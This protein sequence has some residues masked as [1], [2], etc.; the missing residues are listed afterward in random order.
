MNQPEPE[1]RITPPPHVLL[2][3]GAVGL[4]APLRRPQSQSPAGGGEEFGQIA[5]R[6][7]APGPERQ[8]GPAL[9]RTG[10]P[11]NSASK[12][13]RDEKGAPGG[14]PLL[15]PGKPLALITFLALSPGR[16]ASR[17]FLLDLLWADMDTD[18]G[19][20][21][22]RQTLWQIRQLLGEHAFEGREEIRLG[23]PVESDRD[24]FLAAIDSGDLALAVER[25]TGHFLP[26]FAAPGGAEFE[27]WA[28]RERDRLR[29]LFIRA[30]DTLARRHLAGGRPRD[31]VHLA[32][33]IREA[34]PMH[35]GGWRLLLEAVLATNDRVH[36]LVEADALE[37]LLRTEGRESEPATRAILRSVRQSPDT[38]EP[39]ATTTLMAELVGREREFR[40]LTQAWDQ[41][42]HG[43]SA[44]ILLSA[45]AG[46][47]KSRLL[48]DFHARLKTLGARTVLV[49]A[50]PGERDLAGA[51]AADLAAA[52][53][54]LPGSGA[55]SPAA[56][57]T[58]VSLNP[59]LSARFSG[60]THQPESTDQI[61]QR[62]IALA[63]LVQAVAWEAPVAILVDD[64]HWADP[65]STRILL[66]VQPRIATARV[67]LLG[68]T[69]HDRTRAT[70]P[71]ETTI[72]PLEPLSPSD[73][74]N[75]LT[76]LGRLSPG[77]EC[78]TL[79]VTL[80][81]ASG[82]SPLHV[83]DALTLALEKEHLALTGSAWEVK[84][85][86]GLVLEV[87]RGGSIAG[88]VGDLDRAAAWVLT[89]LAT[90]GAPCPTDLVVRASGREGEE[91]RTALRLLEQRGF[92]S[93]VGREWEVAHDEIAETA[94][95]IADPATRRAA[96]RA[97][98]LALA[99]DAGSDE[100]T[101]RR[102]LQL[103]LAGG[104]VHEVGSLILKIRPTIAQL[105]SAEAQAARLAELL[106]RDAE[107]ADLQ[108]VVAGM[109]R[110]RRW[111]WL[112]T[113][114][115]VLVVVTGTAVAV[116]R[117][118]GDA[119]FP[120]LYV[121]L[122]EDSKPSEVRRVV[123]RPEEW[124]TRS[125]FRSA[126]TRIQTPDGPHA[127]ADAA[128]AVRGREW[129]LY[130][131][132]SVDN[133]RTHEVARTSQDGTAYLTDIP[134]DDLFGSLSPDRR[135]IVFA[136]ARWSPPGGDHLDLAIMDSLGGSVHQLTSSPAVEGSPRWDHSGTRIAFV[137]RFREIQPSEV[138]VITT[139]GVPLGCHPLP[140]ADIDDLVGWV[141]PATL[142]VTSSGP[143]GTSILR[144]NLG[145]G[146][147]TEFHPRA[148]AGYLS[149]SPD[150]R[151]VACHCPGFNGEPVGLRIVP[152]RDPADSRLVDLPPPGRI[153]GLAWDS[154]TVNDAALQRIDVTGLGE[155]LARDV[156]HAP[157]V[158]G[159]SG[160]GE[161]MPIPPGVL[162]WW[163]ADTAVIHVD[164]ASG[165]MTPR[166]EGAATIRLTAGG[167]R[168]ATVRVEV[169]G[170]SFQ[171]VLEEQWSALDTT[172]WRSYGEPTPRLGRGPEGTAGLIPNGDGSYP[173]GAYS[174]SA[175]PVAEG[176]G[177][178]AM[179]SAPV[180]RTFWQNIGLNLNRIDAFTGLDQ[181]DHVAGAPPSLQDLEAVHCGFILPAGE[182]AAWL[183][184]AIV[185]T[186]REHQ[187]IPAPPD[188][189]DGRWWTLRVQLFPDGSC[190]YAFNGVPVA[191]SGPGSGLER[192]YRLWL[193][194]H[195]MGTTPMFGPL[196][197]WTGV[198]PGVDWGVLDR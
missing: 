28:D 113:A 167:W 127:L 83:L 115:A 188:Y 158:R 176:L 172:R 185:N 154:P 196:E 121:W 193:S 47:G 69:R 147:Y 34:E 86:D 38:G 43:P 56:A 1:D 31:A 64:L 129:V 52:L 118:N 74:E 61:L 24:Q 18:R 10:A 99:P 68:A 100:M 9:D 11:G 53:A 187:S 93:R 87:E 108:A 117:P 50:N 42:R 120:T 98:G 138:C 96:A 134:R 8:E 26:A 33:R 160:G 32:R 25:Y 77:P 156:S 70:V 81:R 163:T 116:T 190:G 16:S 102:A 66:G 179:I 39:S 44:T 144:L 139:E 161:A 72:L 63:E 141:G 123:V 146:E 48:H 198:K 152:V 30:A 124:N 159:W 125:S 40:A 51:L 36:A 162:R 57:A 157:M 103:L 131:S 5:G 153:I 177:V 166:Q 13:A 107:D 7:I 171:P 41:A 112:A 101:L 76:S 55:V 79:V 148:A 60:V 169:A 170:T 17:E 150:G 37:N 137:R 132:P 194:G 110:G 119:N 62:T 182:G 122:Q 45:P 126:P 197:V 29:A 135:Q 27:Q 80:A 111:P 180:D 92:V 191:R 88:R 22:L 105:R 90:A 109:P 149:I 65:V 82:G 4:Y 189:R 73:I 84:N 174:L 173:S 136:T 130:H 94:L 155:R 2:T 184:H 145:N 133:H 78:G 6:R 14:A 140:E 59:A 106:G 104:A 85:L 71:P 192:P 3:M 183:D 181:W 168:G 178:E 142:L 58:L 95:D 35:E 91:A 165:R 97:L 75:L 186:D 151:W 67:L 114:A 21:A 195:A 175:W 15:G 12:G 19:R 164:S 49:R 128:L 54:E 89:L 143:G 23:L 46:L 20:H